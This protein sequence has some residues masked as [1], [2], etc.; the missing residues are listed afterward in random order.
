[1][2]FTAHVNYDH[3]VVYTSFRADPPILGVSLD[4]QH[5]V[6]LLSLFRAYKQRALASTRPVLADVPQEEP[7]EQRRERVVS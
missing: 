7:Q 2:C 6:F 3:R 1:M 4:G 5:Y